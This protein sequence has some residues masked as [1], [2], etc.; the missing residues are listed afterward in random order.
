MFKYSNKNVENRK[1]RMTTFKIECERTK[2][3]SWKVSKFQKQP[4]Y[5]LCCLELGKRDFY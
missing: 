4:N 5:K 3:R 2:K 1:I